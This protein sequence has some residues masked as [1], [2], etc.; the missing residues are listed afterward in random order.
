M[1]GD[2]DINS[3]TRNHV[4]KVCR[5]RCIDENLYGESL[6]ICIKECIEKIISDSNAD[7]ES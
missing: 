7:R 6:E 2:Q 5:E 3:Y 4:I 1:A